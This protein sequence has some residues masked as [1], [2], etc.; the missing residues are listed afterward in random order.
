MSRCGSCP[1]YGYDGKDPVRTC[2]GN[3]GVE[4]CA[5]KLHEYIG[6][7]SSQIETYNKQVNK[8]TLIYTP[9]PVG[10]ACFCLDAEPSTPGGKRDIYEVSVTYEGLGDLIRGYGITCFSSIEQAINARD[11]HVFMARANKSQ[12]WVVFATDTIDG[13]PAKE[14][15]LEFGRNSG[16]EDDVL[17]ENDGFFFYLL[18]YKFTPTYRRMMARLKQQ[19]IFVCGR[20]DFHLWM[21]KD[22]PYGD[23]MPFAFTQEENCET[24]IL[25]SI[26][27]LK[28]HIGDRETLLQCLTDAD[29]LDDFDVLSGWSKE[30]IETA[31]LMWDLAE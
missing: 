5:D 20:E 3:F 21:R 12:N 13:V 26:K 1:L 30:S 10:E 14:R 8:G 28:T 31:Y 15:L 11:Y 17:K 25:D 19:G 24:P 16:L 6:D 29:I 22:R 9:I 23:V 2:E 7:L 27:E 4:E 18:K